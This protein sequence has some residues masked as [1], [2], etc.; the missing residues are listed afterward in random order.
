MNSGNES[1]KE[2]LPFLGPSAQYKVFKRRWWILFVFTLLVTQQSAFWLTYN[3]VGNHA[4]TFYQTTQALINLIVALGPL[5]YIA[6]VLFTSWLMEAWG[7]RIAVLVAATLDLICGLIRC[8]AQRPED[9]WIVM[10]AQTLNAAA[11]PIS[12][13]IAFCSHF[14]NM[15]TFLLKHSHS[16]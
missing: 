4:L 15:L 11:G 5:V 7:L 12:K 1:L 13:L 8:F 16:Y 9:L 14:V 10:I 3:S 2:K 6:V